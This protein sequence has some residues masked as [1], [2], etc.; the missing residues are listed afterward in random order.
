MLTNSIIHFLQIITIFVIWNWERQSAIKWTQCTNKY[1]ARHKINVPAGSRAPDSRVTN[2]SFS[3]DR[4]NFYYY[5]GD[6]SEG[7]LIHAANQNFVITRHEAPS[8]GKSPQSEQ[9]PSQ[10]VK[11]P[12]QSVQSAPSSPSVGTVG[13]KPSSVQS[14]AL[15]W[16]VHSRPG[17]W[18]YA[19]QCIYLCIALT[20]LRSSLTI[21]AGII[22]VLNKLC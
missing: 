8:F 5:I 1:T 6:E 17:H 11:S 9:S 10:S 21:P 14:G 15:C 13:A 20:L 4:R 16:L 18:F 19:V 2:P 12:S 3:P 22:N 7:K